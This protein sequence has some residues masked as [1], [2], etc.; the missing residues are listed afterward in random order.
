MNLITAAFRVNSR[1][2]TLPVES[3]YIGPGENI[4]QFL[5]DDSPAKYSTWCNEGF[6]IDRF[7]SQEEFIIIKEHITALILELLTDM[8]ID[9]QNFTLE[10]YHNFVSTEQH[11]QLVDRIRAGS[12]GLG[13]ILFEK[14]GI[15]TSR[16]D[17]EASRICSVPVTCTKTFNHHGKPYKVKHFFIRIVR[18][19]TAKD[20]NPPHKDTHINHLRNAVNLY[21]P[22]AGSDMNSSLPIIPGSHLW[23]E[24]DITKTSGVT[25]INGLKYNVPAIVSAVNGLRLI[26]PNPAYTRAMLFSPYAIHGGGINF[27]PD[28]TRIS[29]EIRF[30]RD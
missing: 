12:Q 6:I 5:D 29:L 24:Q 18:P 20:N 22:V 8:N 27:N 11:L 14:L 28:T 4:I 23:S 10:K 30:W 1:N 25:R 2:I 7:L 17:E 3:E 9:S 15:S 16:L 19:G 26:T 21:Y 13:G